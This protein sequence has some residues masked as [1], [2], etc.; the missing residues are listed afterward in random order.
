MASFALVFPEHGDGEEGTITNV[1]GARLVVFW[2]EPQM[3]LKAGFEPLFIFNTSLILVTA[4]YKSVIKI[5]EHKLQTGL[6]CTDQLT[7][8][9][10]T[11]HRVAK[12]VSSIACHHLKKNVEDMPEPKFL[13]FFHRIDSLWE[14]IPSWNW[15]PGGGEGRAENEVNSSFKN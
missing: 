13:N 12:I 14:P 1:T 8:T 15:F 2:N 11:V 4:I 7:V 10:N 9:L 3:T 6:T 5:T